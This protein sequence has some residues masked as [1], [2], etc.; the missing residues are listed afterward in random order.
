MKL[1][2][3][4][5]QTEAAAQYYDL[6][7]DF[8]SFT[9]AMDTASEDVKNRF[10]QAISQKIK[11]KKIRARASRGYKQFEK[12]YEINVTTVSID[13]Y[14]DNYVVVVKGSNGKEYFL[15]P[16]FKVQVL[17][18]AEAEKPEAQAPP[19]PPQPKPEAPQPPPQPPPSAAVPQ[20]APE[21]PVKEADGGSGIV[22]KYPVERIEKDLATWL[23]ALLVNKNSNLKRYIPREGVSRT[24]DRRST[25]SYGITIPVE[26]VPA[27][28]VETI[29]QQLQT[30]SKHANNV[31]AIDN[32]YR[33]EKFDVRGGKYVIIIKKITNY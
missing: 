7:K 2:R 8:F 19:Q 28:D 1:R 25:I 27:L 24:K 21:Q 33:L 12:D 16:G 13:D 26:E 14:Y 9:H 3:I 5:E 18:T 10:E 15:K 31:N 17:G 23:P 11:G 20:A 6:G 30:V 4:L 32:I 22:R 29:K